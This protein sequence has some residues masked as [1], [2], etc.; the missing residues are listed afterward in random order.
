MGG[1]L[2]GDLW[3]CLKNQ[4]FGLHKGQRTEGPQADV[5][6]NSLLIQT[7]EKRRIMTHMQQLM[8]S[9]NSHQVS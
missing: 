2:G 1:G 6:S 7:A 3:L 5:S 8:P 9:N 4:S